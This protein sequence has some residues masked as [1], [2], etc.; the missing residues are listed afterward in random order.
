MVR[1]LHFP[2]KVGDIFTLSVSLIISRRTLLRSWR[3]LTF[4]A[5]LISLSTTTVTLQTLCFLFTLCIYVLSFIDLWTIAII[6]LQNVNRLVFKWCR[7]PTRCNNNGL[8]LIPISSTCFGRW[9]HPSS[10][11]LDCVYCL[12]YYT[13]SMLPAGSLDPEELLRIQATGRQQRDCTSIIPQAVNT[14]WCSW[15]WVKSSPETCWA[16]WN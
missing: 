15:R 2:Y 7:Q 11:A 1:K 4:M 10:G 14:V 3:W 6:V 9:F 13:P 5:P 8:L 16:D 12:W